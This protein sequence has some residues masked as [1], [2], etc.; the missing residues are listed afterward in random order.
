VNV[1]GVLPRVPERR[2]AVRRNGGGLRAEFAGDVHLRPGDVS[3]H[4]HAAG[5]DHQP[6]AVDRVFRDAVGGRSNDLAAVDP[7]VAGVAVNVVRR[8]VH[9]AAG[10]LQECHAGSVEA[11][12]FTTKARREDTK[13][14]KD[15]Q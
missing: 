15:S 12:S 1:V 5:H 7:D 10:E 8:V 9:R 13:T 6:G 4:V 2:R 14:T 11:K 3:V